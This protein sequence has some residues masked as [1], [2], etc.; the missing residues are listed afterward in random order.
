MNIW[1]PFFNRIFSCWLCFFPF[2]LTLLL[3]YYNSI[4]KSAGFNLITVQ[5]SHQFIIIQ[6][7]ETFI[8]YKYANLMTVWVCDYQVHNSE[9]RL[10]MSL[11]YWQQHYCYNTDDDDDDGDGD[12]MTFM[13]ILIN[14]NCSS[15][16]WCYKMFLYE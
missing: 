11:W 2:H 15:S 3:L 5:H 7:Y 16:S 9:H 13:I 12:T 4:I 14:K 8:I 6:T 10:F 1:N